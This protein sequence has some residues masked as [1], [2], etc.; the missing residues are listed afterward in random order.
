M[1]GSRLGEDDI[2]GLRIKNE[3]EPGVS[4]TDKEYRMDVV[5][6]LNDGATLDLEMQRDD[7]NNWV[8]RSLAYLC[9]EFDNLNH[10]EDYSEVKPVYQIGF[11]DFDLFEDHPEFFAHYQL[12]NA[13]DNH[14][15]TDRFNL[16]VV[17]L[18]QIELATNEYKARGI[19]KWARLFKS[20]T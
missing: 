3:V 7:Y 15:F 9:R 13:K 4:I 1:L 8:F 2:V 11:L 18:N 14:L 5:V 12:K 16:V 10:G 17:S 20:K 6:E 19:D